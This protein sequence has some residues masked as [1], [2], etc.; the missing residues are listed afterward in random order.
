MKNNWSDY[1]YLFQN[2]NIDAIFS[3]SSFPIIKSSDIKKFAKV[4]GFNFDK[5]IIPNQIH[6]NNV[7]ISSK[8]GLIQN[9]DGV[10]SCDISLICSL[11]V[12][13]CMPIYFVHRS[14]PI[15]GLVHVGWKG[16][17]KKILS[18][19][20]S[21]LLANNWEL[22][23]FEILIGPSIQQCCFEVDANIIDRFEKDFLI[24]NKNG[25]F[26]VSLQLS[27]KKE[28]IRIGFNGENI[29]IDNQCS[30]CNEQ[31]FYSY[32]R[33]NKNAGR[34]IALLGRRSSF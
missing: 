30:C 19:T 23:E 21:K 11:K 22:S 25:K 17:S 28:L 27:A 9:C 24:K 6:S 4:S 32:R 2:K 7:E 1:S 20:G 18:T 16:L 3:H 5:F 12:A 13:D 10:F 15:F 33:D 8:P 14:C 34:M 31:K 26:S 29:M